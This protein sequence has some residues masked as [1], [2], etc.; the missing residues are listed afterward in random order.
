MI[1]PKKVKEAAEKV[2]DE[3]YDL[4]SEEDRHEY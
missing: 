1:E 3:N 4:R 2:R